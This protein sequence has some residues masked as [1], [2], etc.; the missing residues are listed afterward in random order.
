MGRSRRY[1][2]DDKVMVYI[3]L[4]SNDNNIKRTSRDTGVPMQTIREWRAKWQE[5][6]PP[7]ADE[8]MAEISNDFV[9]RAERVRDMLLEKFEAEVRAGTL[10]AEKMP[11]AIAILDDKI[12][13]HRG[14]ATSRSETVHALPP[15]EELTAIFAGHIAKALTQAREREQDIIDAEF[16]EEQAKALSP[17]QGSSARSE[18]ATALPVNTTKE[19]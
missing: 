4:T 5:E 18:A 9:A 6:G 13:L 2:D 12:R 1:T 15:P 8:A 16:T 17:P 14:L 3:A 10:K 11:V 7:I 19:N